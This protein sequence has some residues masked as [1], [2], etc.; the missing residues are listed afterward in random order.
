M[1]KL[2]GLII[3]LSSA[4]LLVT[5]ILVTTAS[6][7]HSE[8]AS[9]TEGQLFTMEE[10]GEIT[11]EE[12]IEELVHRK[13]NRVG[14]DSQGPLGPF[15]V[16]ADGMTLYLFT[17]DERNASNCSGG[18]ADA[19]PPLLVEGEPIA[20]GG[21]RPDRLATIER[22]DGGS[23]VTYNGKPLYYFANDEKPGDTLGQDRGDV[24]F[25]VSPD[26]GP[27]RT[28]SSVIAADSSRLGTILT[29]ASGNSLYLFTRDE[30]NV[31][32]CAGRCALAWPPLL[33]VE[34]PIAGEGLSESRIGTTTRADGTK[35]VTY[36]GWP[37]Y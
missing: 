27:I 17:R 33:T 16:D 7:D 34:E 30:R 21:I 28:T 10:A 26:G 35:H 2:K 23:Q 22:E 6:A 11:T 36:T 4:S 37:L 13:A 20:A 29:D 18:C 25:V 5:L 15:L 19:W 3:A 31:S 1:G 12:L 9:F 24:W 8:F 14:V 32:N